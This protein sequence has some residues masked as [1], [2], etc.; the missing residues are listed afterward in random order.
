MEVDENDYAYIQSVEVVKLNHRESGYAFEIFF[1]QK[2]GHSH[3]YRH[4]HSRSEI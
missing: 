4:L 2:F 1:P 3:T